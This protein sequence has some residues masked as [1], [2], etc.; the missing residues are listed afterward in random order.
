M[1]VSLAGIGRRTAAALLSPVL[2]VVTLGIGYMVWG[3]FAWRRGQT[4]ALQVLGMRCWRLK[5]Q[6]VAGFWWMSY[7][8]IVGR[9][10]DSS[11]AG[12]P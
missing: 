12:S 4:P 10:A 5:D 6:R 8:E 1:G 9:L 11:W 2:F 3:P 7:R